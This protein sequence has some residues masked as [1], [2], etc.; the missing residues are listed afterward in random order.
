LLWKGWWKRKDK[1]LPEPEVREALSPRNETEMTLPKT[2][3]G[4][5]VDR[6]VRRFPHLCPANNSA[7]AFV[8]WMRANDGVG[9]HLQG[10]LYDAYRLLCGTTK[11]VPLSDKRFGKALEALGCKRKRL[12]FYEGRVR[13][14]PWQITITDG[15]DPPNLEAEIGRQIRGWESPKGPS[16]KRTAKIK[17]AET[18]RKL[19]A[20]M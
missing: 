13:S 17:R 5:V 3:T 10:D 16:R 2:D 19:V 6:Y 9:K 7:E 8:E 12:D 14:K 1:H 18:K 20:S 11:T 15:N 4:T